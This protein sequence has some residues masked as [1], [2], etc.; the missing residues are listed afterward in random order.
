MVT[1][2]LLLRNL[3]SPTSSFDAR[4]VLRKSCSAEIVSLLRGKVIVQVLLST[5]VH[6]L[7]QLVAVCRLQLAVDAAVPSPPTARCLF[8]EPVA[9]GSSD[10]ATG[11]I[12]IFLYN[13]TTNALRPST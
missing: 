2:T 10:K 11:T 5:S 8:G 1:R 4:Q 12:M 7:S 13:C 3:M 6:T 9:Q